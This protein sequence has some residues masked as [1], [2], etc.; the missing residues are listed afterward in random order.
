M[1]TVGRKPG[2]GGKRPGSGRKPGT[3]NKNT[4]EIKVW[5]RCSARRRCGQVRDVSPARRTGERQPEHVMDGRMMSDKP[6]GPRF[7]VQPASDVIGF[8]QPGWV[9]TG[10]AT[11]LMI[12]TGSGMTMIEAAN[13]L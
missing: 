5:P 10:L 2:S 8:G 6:L 12:W 7:K 4:T 13:R 11:G 1:A 9:V 3:A